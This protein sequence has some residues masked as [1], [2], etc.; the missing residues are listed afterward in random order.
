[1]KILEFPQEYLSARK[2]LKDETAKVIEK[3]IKTQ[4]ITSIEGMEESSYIVN[5]LLKAVRIALDQS[6]L[7]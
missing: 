6:L 2:E 3:I 7:Q 1:I 5:K 4:E